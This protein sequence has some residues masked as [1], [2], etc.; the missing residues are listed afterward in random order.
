MSSYEITPFEHHGHKLPLAFCK[1][2]KKQET[3]DATYT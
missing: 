1:I 3:C 2:F